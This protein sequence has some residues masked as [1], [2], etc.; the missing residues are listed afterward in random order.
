[1][2][3]RTTPLCNKKVQIPRTFGFEP[4]ACDETRG[5]EEINPYGATAPN[6]HLVGLTSGASI[7]TTDSLPKEDYMFELNKAAKEQLDMHFA[8]KEVSPIRVYMAAG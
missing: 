2:T 6:T 8:G 7:T 4:V 5:T 3:V 1:M